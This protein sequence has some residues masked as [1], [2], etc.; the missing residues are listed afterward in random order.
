MCNVLGYEKG[1]FILMFSLCVHFVKVYI[2]E[3]KT[4][5]HNGKWY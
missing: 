3:W 4:A 1:T 5:Y 2:F